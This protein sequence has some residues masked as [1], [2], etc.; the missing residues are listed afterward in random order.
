VVD[1]VLYRKS[2]IH[3]ANNEPEPA[4]EMLERIAR[5][6]PSGLLADDALYL[7]ADTYNFRFN[8]RRKAADTYRRILFEH[9]G[10][11][12]VPQARE[13]FRELNIELP[14]IEKNEELPAGEE[15]FFKGIIP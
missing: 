4:V 10:S 3:L 5:E 15:Q 14:D 9:P 6:F 13:K 12:Y 8:D 2:R 11:I 7:L 1:D